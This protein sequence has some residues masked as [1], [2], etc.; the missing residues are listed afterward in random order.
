[1][2]PLGCIPYTPFHQK[3]FIKIFH[4]LKLIIV[5][6]ILILKIIIVKKII[7]LQLL[8]KKNFL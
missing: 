8:Q 1:M 7:L 4:K 5:E 2:I 6:I 3:L